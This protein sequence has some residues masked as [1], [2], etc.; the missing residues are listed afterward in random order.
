MA[1]KSGWS[2]AKVC[3]SATAVPGLGLPSA[4]S[5]NWLVVPSSKVSTTG[6]LPAGMSILPATKS[7]A[8]IGTKPFFSR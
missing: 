6:C 8:V 1:G 2:A 4:P 3:M 7:A 5:A